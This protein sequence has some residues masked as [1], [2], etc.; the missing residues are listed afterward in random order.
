[1]RILICDD[2]VLI[3]ERL[4]KYINDFFRNNNLKCPEILSFDSGEALFTAKYN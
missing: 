2:D 3:R 1:M 4:Q